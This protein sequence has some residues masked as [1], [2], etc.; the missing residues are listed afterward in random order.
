MYY[1]AILLAMLPCCD[2]NRCHHCLQ[3]DELVPAD[4]TTQYGGFYINQGELHYRPMMDGYVKSFI[5][6]F[7]FFTSLITFHP[8]PKSSLSSI[9]KLKLTIVECHHF[10]GGLHPKSC[11]W[12]AL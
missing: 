8:P 5:N 6:F 7:T 1:S 12:K 3:Y 2:A 11:A 9:L 4:W 10:W